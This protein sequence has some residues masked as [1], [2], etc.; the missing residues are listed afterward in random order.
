MD[1]IKELK[2]YQ[3]NNPYHRLLN[4][5]LCETALFVDPEDTI[6]FF[7]KTRK[8]YKE[9]HRVGKEIGLFN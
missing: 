7:M 3:K 1:V 6:R 2:K 9:E 5:G 8:L 4:I